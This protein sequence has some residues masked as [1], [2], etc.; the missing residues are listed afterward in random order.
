MTL[1]DNLFRKLFILKLPS[2]QTMKHLDVMLGLLT[3]NTLH[4]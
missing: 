4:L 3:E 1:A 2:Q